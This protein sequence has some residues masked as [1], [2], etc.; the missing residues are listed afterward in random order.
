V[1][2]KEDTM[3]LKKEMLLKLYHEVAIKKEIEIEFSIYVY[4]I[5]EQSGFLFSVCK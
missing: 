2:S 3:I 5:L 1:V 4:L